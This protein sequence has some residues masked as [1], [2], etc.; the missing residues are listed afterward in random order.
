M[1]PSPLPFGDWPHQFL[2]PLSNHRGDEYG[3]GL[4]GRSRFL[5][6]VTDAA[7]AQWPEDRPL[8]VRFSATDWADGGW[9]PEERVELSRHLVAHGVDLVDV[10]SG[11]PVHNAVSKWSP[12]TRCPSPEPSARARP[13]P[14]PRSA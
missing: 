9:T 4:D 13:C 1:A 5:V 2:S 7:R 6:Q 14:S 3:G 12:A 11:G 8:F 10:T